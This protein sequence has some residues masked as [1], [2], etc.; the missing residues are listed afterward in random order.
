MTPGNYRNLWRATASLREA[1]TLANLSEVSGPADEPPKD[2]AGLQSWAEDWK[3]RALDAVHKAREFI[4]R[5]AVVMK[6]RGRAIVNRISTGLSAIRRATG[7]KLKQTLAPVA[8]ALG[9]AQLGFYG[10]QFVVTAG[11]VYLAYRFLLARK[12]A[13]T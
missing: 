12:G 9:A 5:P 6:E 4:E 7:Q 10:M 1:E 11:I 2:D 13:L 3:G 8:A